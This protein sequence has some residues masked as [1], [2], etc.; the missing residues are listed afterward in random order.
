MLKSGRTGAN[1]PEEGS[2]P[3]DIA[4]LP[5]LTIDEDVDNLME[6]FEEN[7]E[8][9]YRDNAARTLFR[10]SRGDN[11]TMNS[12]RSLYESDVLYTMINGRRYCKDYCQPNDEEEQTRCQILHGVFLYLLDQK[13]TTVPLNNPH[14]IL[15]IGTGTGE[16]AMA[17]ADEYPEAEIIGTDIAK[18]QP[19]AVPLNVFFEIDD[20]EEPWTWPE[21]D[22]DFI[23]FRS[24]QGAFKDWRYVYSEAY[25]H[26]KPGGWIEVLDFDDHKVL[27][28][29][30][31]DNPE[32]VQWY[33]DVVEASKISGRPK[34]AAHLE[35]DVLTELGFVD[36]KTT[37]KTI[38]MGI[39]P[40]DPEEQRIGKHFLVT[41]LSGIE[42][43]SLRPLVENLSWELDDVKKCCE[44]VINATRNV[45]LDPIK[46]RGMGFKV[47]VLVGRK[48]GGTTEDDSS[49]RTTK[50]VTG[51][52]VH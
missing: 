29:Y 1:S 43:V 20:A 18:I 31:D 37:L 40:E 27:F 52:I 48:P 4:A 45:A 10:F 22:F 26:L 28:S 11:D 44:T 30:F 25:K 34:T 7:Y 33:A 24:M 12:T 49:I 47:K 14:K 9:P 6:D 35:P 39:W 8:R 36:V 15:D 2:L 17:L 16:W 38:P 5:P 51:E 41:Q 3:R 42:A 50:N 32:V 21:D 46:G 13:L 23:H 19:S